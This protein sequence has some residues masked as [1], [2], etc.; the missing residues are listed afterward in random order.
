MQADLGTLIVCCDGLTGFP[1][2][3]EATWPQSTVQ[4]CTV[5]AWTASVI[6]EIVSWDNSVPSVRCRWWPMSRIVIPPAY[7]EQ[8]PNLGNSQ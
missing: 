1:K 6:F 3:I 4:T 5:L 8:A 7:N 2:A